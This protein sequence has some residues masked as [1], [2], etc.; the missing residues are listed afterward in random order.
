MCFPKP[1]THFKHLFSLNIVNGT[2]P[3]S[4]APFSKGSLKPFPSVYSIYFLIILFTDHVYHL[5]VLFP[6]ISKH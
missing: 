2:I 3:D 4:S 5:L 1:K 6:G